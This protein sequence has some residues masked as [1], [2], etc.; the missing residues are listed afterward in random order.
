MFQALYRSRKSLTFLSLQ[1]FSQKIPII[2]VWQ[3]CKYASVYLRHVQA[4]I[5]LKVCK[6]VPMV[7]IS[8]NL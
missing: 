3:C 4:K 1:I 7:R 8:S 2:D 6:K 5:L